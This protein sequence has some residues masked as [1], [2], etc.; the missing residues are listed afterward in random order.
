LL[1]INALD[2]RYTMWNTF[3]SRSLEY[4]GLAFVGVNKCL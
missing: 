3:Y 1:S 2:T 4:S